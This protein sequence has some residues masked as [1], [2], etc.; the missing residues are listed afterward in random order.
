MIIDNDFLTKKE[1]ENILDTIKSKNNLFPL[2]FLPGN[3]SSDNEDLQEKHYVFSHVLYYRFAP[4]SDFYEYF[5]EVFLKFLN[6]NNIEFR[7]ILSARVNFYPARAEE[8]SIGYPHTDWDFDHKVFLYYI[9]DSDGD[10]L[11]YKETVEENIKIENLKNLNV[12]KSIKP[13]MGTGVIFDGKNYHSASF[14]IKS[15]Y[16][17]ILNVSFL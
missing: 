7:A 13:Q 3:V 15:K 14:P 12:V 5:M 6:K 8:D 10:T 11:I 2:H 1:Q 17:A 16:R 4:R 9:N